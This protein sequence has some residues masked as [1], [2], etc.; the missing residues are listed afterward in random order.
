MFPLARDLLIIELKCDGVKDFCKQPENQEIMRLDVGRISVK[1]QKLRAGLTYCYL[2]RA[3]TVY[4]G[5]LV[6]VGTPYEQTLY[7]ES[8]SATSQFYVNTEATPELPKFSLWIILP[9]FTMA[10]LISRGLLQETQT[11]NRKCLFTRNY[12]FV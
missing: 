5:V 2:V 3:L 7:N 10:T 12:V 6:N 9:L 1:Q 11:L 8:W 4:W